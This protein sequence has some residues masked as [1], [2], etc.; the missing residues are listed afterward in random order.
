MLA[1]AHAVAVEA[2][3][4]P[5]LPHSLPHDFTTAGSSPPHAALP[6]ATHAALP[7]PLALPQP[8][9]FAPGAA[10]HN[11]PYQPPRFACRAC[12]AVFCGD[13]AK[14]AEGTRIAV[15][16]LCGY[17][18]RPYEEVAA[19]RA[20]Y[21][22]R[23]EGFGLADFA[24]ALKYPF[25]NVVSLLFGAGL[26]GVL[27]FA[28]FRGQILAY[29]IMFG[30]IAVVINKVAYGKLDRDFLPDFSSFS[31]YDD[32]FMP[33][34]LGVGVTV[35][36]VGPTLLLVIALLFGW[37]GGSQSTA[38]PMAPAVTAAEAQSAQTGG[39]L[40]TRDLDALIDSKGDPRKEEEI[41]RKVQ[42]MSPAAQVAQ[43]ID[44]AE[45]EPGV[46]ERVFGQL[47]AR[48]GLVALLLFL[49]VVWAVVYYPMA[50]A[51]AGYTEDVWSVVNPLVGLDT[52]QRMGV[53]YAKAFAMYVAVQAV[54][55]VVSFAVAVVTAPFSLPLVGNLPARFIDGALAF[56]I[57]L[58]VACL[59]GLALFKS[60][61][62]L[63]IDI[64]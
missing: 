3:A 43:Q 24:E 13:C 27:L 17:F 7:P 62:R 37:L 46:A 19:A 59:L 2:A 11:H 29:A 21:E 26:Y 32:L 14:F 42:A 60:A 15:C 18:C 16:G 33:L 28:G 40:T 64:D 4:Q 45:R 41:R 39:P 54:G 34:L 20:Q 57:N 53:V 48:P 56:Y 63:G 31:A 38:H 23:Q 58:V 10:C 6:S 47:T 52:I 1:S 36:T 22:H 9:T 55:L 8:P 49:A 12:G 25:R 61:D 30:C 51:V 35:V 50:I 44:A 5:S